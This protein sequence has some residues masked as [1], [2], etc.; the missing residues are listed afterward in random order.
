MWHR[1][2]TGDWGLA[3]L[4]CVVAAPVFNRRNQRSE[5]MSNALDTELFCTSC[6]Y[7]L[8]GLCEQGNCPE[9]DPRRIDYFTAYHR[10]A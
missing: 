2:S 9:C 7:N 6:G 1:F 10:K 8:R 5:S 3:V 4:C